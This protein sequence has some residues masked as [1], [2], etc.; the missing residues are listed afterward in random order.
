M[1]TFI[2]ECEKAIAWSNEMTSEWLRTGMFEGDDSSESEATI[3]KIIKELGDHAVTKSHA[4]HLSLSRCEEMG[5]NVSRLESDQNI[6][7][8]VLSLHHACMLTFSETPAIKII[9]NH[10]G[11]AFIKIVGQILIQGQQGAN[12][13]VEGCPASAEPDWRNPMPN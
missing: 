12:Q 6:Q 5:L 13:G 7:D 4:R 2:G 1:P 3:E 8:A 11:V 10:D 9:E